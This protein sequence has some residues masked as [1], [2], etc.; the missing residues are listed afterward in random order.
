MTTLSSSAEKAQSPR[1]LAALTVGAI[2]VVYGD[3]GTSPLYALR[4]SLAHV[5]SDGISRSEVIGTVSLLLWALLIIV[6][7]KYIV[8]IMRADNR[9]EGGTL[10]LVALAQRALGG[11][12]KSVF[13]LGL[14]G[15]A[16]FYGDSIITPAISVMSAVEGLN[17]VTPVFEPYVVPVT[18]VILFILFSVQSRGTE[19]VS[20]YFGPITT[21]WF[22][23]IG[24]LGLMH[25][26]DDMEVFYALNP[27]YGINFLI[28][29]GMLGI[30]VLGSVFLAV[31]G[32]EAV[33][34]DMG[35]FGKKPIR[36]GWFSLVLPALALNYM[37]QGAFVLAHPE[38]AVSPFYMMV[39]QW[40]LI[41]MIILATLATIIACQAVITGAFS[42][43]Q[44][45]IQLG[46]LPRMEIRFTSETLAG[47]IYL[48]AVNN[49][50]LVGV[51]CLVLLFKTSHNLASAYGIAVSAT[52]VV[53]TCLMFIVI[54]K[55]WKWN[56]FIAFGL[57]GSILLV[58]VS[59]F[60]ANLLKV[61]Q[62]GWAPLVLAFVLMVIMSTWVRGN[63]IVSDKTRNDTL[64]LSTLL[65]TLS[66]VQR[67][68]GTAVFLTSDPDSAP[69]ALLHNLKHNKVLHN[70]NII[71]TVRT[72]TQPR[73]DDDE[74]TEVTPLSEDFW[75]VAVTYGY[76][77]NPNVPQ[78][79]A[80][81]RKTGVEV[82]IMSTSFFLG[83]RTFKMSPTPRMAMWRE[84]LYF[85][86]ARSAANATEFF[87]IPSG[88]VV[89]LGAQI[90]I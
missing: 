58:N 16:L 75:Q 76:M 43:T 59:F 31:T 22:L 44:Q 13:Y 89:E 27:Y 46:L 50:L 34:A 23:T 7:L 36:L 37:G 78:A 61:E 39:P 82:D 70:K 71:L 53:D 38:G 3:I 55:V 29:H 86:L 40:A 88:R 2:G 56:P 26:T 9:G 24:F 14:I 1:A 74:R 17:L 45:A 8:L 47:Q 60:S 52:M 11:R 66:K 51:L 35:H 77:E 73:V 64:P 81:C 5:V 62:G 6:T 54:T 90:L 87:G 63:K 33:Y 28:N 25:L 10:S 42:L 4:E 68:P 83:R 85:W 48:P 69:H 67:V 72:I 49:I 32:A 41:P 65:S 84:K 18:I 15:A 20:A 30:A 12:T 79:L 21:V 57:I 19:K 80:R